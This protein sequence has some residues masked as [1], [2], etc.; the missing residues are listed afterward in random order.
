MNA[1]LWAEVLK[2]RRS[3]V[4]LVTAF[5]MVLGVVTLLG[6]ITIGLRAGNPE[7]VN[8]AGSA[9]SLD[10]AG[11]QLGAVQVVAVAGLLGSGIML[12]WIFGREFT[13]GAI[14]GLF[15]LPTSRILI[16][17]AKLL[18]YFLWAIVV[19][20]LLAV[21]VFIL[22]VL[23]GYGQPPWGGLITIAVLMFLNSCIAVPIAW[24]TTL[25]RSVLAGIGATVGLIIIAQVGV[26]AGVG[27][28]VPVAA[29]ALWALPTANA[30]LGLVA[31]WLVGF[32]VLTCRSW[33]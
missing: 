27:A 30:E 7:L 26:L 4:G 16:A 11:L 12:S 3:P 1:A 2:L 28:W 29:P 8:K 19:S 23:L 25:S 21:G 13:E 32:A 33:A 14:S 9:A 17:W 15:G 6:G 31:L 5:A 24:V 22:G 20:V 10:W 18:A